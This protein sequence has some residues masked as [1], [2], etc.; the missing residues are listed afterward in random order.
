MRSTPRHRHPR[1]A[2]AIHW[3]SHHDSR[4]RLM[5]KAKLARK[6]PSAR[7][8][9]K[10]ADR[11]AGKGGEHRVAVVQHPPVL[12]NLAKTMDRAIDL[13]KQAAREGA[14]LVTFPET[15]LP[16]YPDW[17][18]RLRPGD[19]FKLS[20][21]IHA[22]LIRN[23]V[24]VEAG[25][26]APLQAAAKRLKVTVV[27]GLQELDGAYSRSSIYNT[28]VTIGPDGRV[29]N[30]HRKLM[31]TNPERMVWAVGDG[32]GLRVV[33]TPAGRV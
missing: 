8:A 21:E 18:W 32:A 4:R 14:R 10:R 15:F 12:L 19:D 28:M 11:G 5:S 13:A 23:C 22:Q 1:P 24:D 20:Q 3:A 25:G 33:D 7:G 6:P 9:A 17:V 26:L 27:I 2:E 29:M 31:P 30:K 16:G